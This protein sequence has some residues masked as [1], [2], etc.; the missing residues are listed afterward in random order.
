MDARGENQRK[1]LHQN[2]NEPELCGHGEPTAR[3][4]YKMHNN[5]NEM[6][7]GKD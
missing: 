3:H 4:I 7:A 2:S 6:L 5:G 1:C